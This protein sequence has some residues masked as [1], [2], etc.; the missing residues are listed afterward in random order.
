MQLLIKTFSIHASAKEATCLFVPV[1]A[2]ASFQS[3]PPRRRRQT[4]RNKIVSV[5]DFSIHASAKEATH[6]NPRSKNF[7]IFSIHASAKEATGFEAVQLSP[8]V[9]FQSTPPRR[10]RLGAKLYY[11]CKKFS[12]HASAKEATTHTHIQYADNYIFNPR[13]REGGDVVAYV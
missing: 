12:I 10:R 11:D 5:F 13:L 9:V 4:F 7:Q 3:T 8:N 1:F 2:T 6:L